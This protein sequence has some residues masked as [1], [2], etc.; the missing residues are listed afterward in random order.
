M[1]LQLRQSRDEIKG[2]AILW[3]VLFH[4]QLGLTGIAHQIQQIGY[5]GVD[6]FFFLTG[7]GLYYSLQKSSDLRGYVQRRILRLLPSY[8]PFCLLWLGVMLPLFNLSVVDSFRTIVG[9]LTMFGFWAGVPKVINWYVGALVMALVIAPFAYALLSKGNKWTWC[10]L[11]IVALAIGGCFIGDIRYMAVSR[12]PVFLIGMG[13]AKAN[14]VTTKRLMKITPLAL[15]L[16]ISILFYCFRFQQDQLITYA[17]YWH[18]FMLIAPALCVVLA[19]VFSKLNRFTKYF[20][21]LRM[22]GRASFEIFL[23]NVWVE[24]LGKKFGLA[25]TPTQWLIYS[26]VSVAIGVIYHITITTIQSKCNT[27]R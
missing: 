1:Q 13:M 12:I 18:P 5:G 10:T 11:M 22:L 25:S 6:I 17:L 4:A 21:P 16:G 20:A 7:F 14:E 23:C 15:V 2:L 27:S 8:L 19:W 26:L 24:V 9:N 3:V